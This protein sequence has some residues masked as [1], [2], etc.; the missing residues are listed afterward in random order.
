[1]IVVRDVFQ[2]KYGKGDALVALFKEGM[3]DWSERD[4]RIMTDVS[5]PFFTVVTEE[6]FA[7]LEEWE[8]ELA[9]TFEHPEFGAW[10]AKMEPLV[11]TGSREFYQIQ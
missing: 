10:F 2:A 4:F 1:M 11:K 7:S 3:Q 5:G 6:E 9:K 8:Q